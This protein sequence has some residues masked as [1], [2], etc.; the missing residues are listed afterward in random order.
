MRGL[1]ADKH[2]AS[3]SHRPQVYFCSAD[4]PG[5]CVYKSLFFFGAASSG[6]VAP[7]L[8]LFVFL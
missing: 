1:A 4:V 5:M 3:K 7:V 8:S 6:T 2:S